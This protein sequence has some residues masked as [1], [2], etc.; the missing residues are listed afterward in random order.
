MET[1]ELSKK[2]REHLE[3]RSRNEFIE[4]V[5]KFAIK[6]HHDTNHYYDD[7]LP[8]EFH[9]RMVVKAAKDFLFLIPKEFHHI[10][11]SACWCHDT[12]EDARQ[13]YNDIMAISSQEVAEIVRAVTN[14]GRGR[15]RT[16]RMPDFV[17]KDIRDTEFATF[18]KLC[19]RIANVQYSKLTGSSMFGK[20]KK[21]NEH[22]KAQLYKEGQFEEVWEYLE[23]LFESTK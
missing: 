16:E 2:E 10:V 19:D 5:E 23:E 17:Y 7:Y 22:F 9:L 4:K 8:Y 20:Y 12:I 11:I 1:K 21:E 6:A 3:Q 15:D 13:S 14:Y 18:V